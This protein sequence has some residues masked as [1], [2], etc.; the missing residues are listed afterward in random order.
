MNILKRLSIICLIAVTLVSFTACENDDGGDGDKLS[1]PEKIVSVKKVSSKETGTVYDYVYFSLKSGTAVDTATGAST[2]WDLRFSA[3]TRIQTNSGVTADQ[4]G[5]GGD[6]GAAYSGST[7]FAA[8]V[9]AGSLTIITDTNPW[10]DGMGPARQTLMNEAISFPGY[11]SGDGLA[12]GSAYAGANYSA[13]M[14]YTMSGMPPVYVMTNN[15]YVVKLADGSGYAKFQI[16][17]AEYASENDT[18]NAGDKTT[19]YTFLIEYEVL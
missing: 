10:I 7:D 4:L 19:T 6:G 13:D 8:S 16:L 12:S 3:S 14:F 11:D 1:G 5:S 15:V 18:P 2:D 17:S 9:D